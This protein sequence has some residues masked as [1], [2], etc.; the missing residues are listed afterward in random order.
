LGNA[1]IETPELDAKLLMAHVLDCRTIDLYVDQ[2]R[3]L[4]DN[5]KVDL[6]RLVAMRLDRVPVQYIVGRTEFM[7]LDFFV[8]DSV[9]IPRPE[10]ELIVEAVSGL[11]GE[12][13]QS[14]HNAISRNV[15]N[16]L[17]GLGVS[18]SDNRDGNKKLN[19]IDIGTGSG[20]IAVSIAVMLENIKVF[21]TD[22]SFD[23]LKVAAKNAKL[24]QVSGKVKVLQGNMFDALKAERGDLKADFIVSN[25]PYIAE[26]ELDS[27][28]VEVVKY[29]PRQDLSGGGDGLEFF[30]IIVSEAKDWLNDGGYLILETGE[31][32]LN[33][34]KL[35]MDD[36]NEGDSGARSTIKFVGSL[37]DLQGIDRVV[38]AQST[39]LR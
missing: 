30:K 8:N 14:V 29:E 31:S 10:T 38:V 28:Q 26:G 36:S 20:N 17:Y 2:G 18:G 5:A 37:K 39:I 24:H 19:I 22:I 27:L 7:S 11:S 23:A 3:I 4:D 21:A 25:P 15:F 32:Q 35:L 34:V 12:K 33:D 6:G 13:S 9:L 1:G 16:S